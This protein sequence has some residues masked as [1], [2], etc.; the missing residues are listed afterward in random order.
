MRILTL[1]QLAIWRCLQNVRRKKMDMKK[2]RLAFRK[3][4]LQNLERVRSKTEQTLTRNPNDPS[5]WGRGFYEDNLVMK[6]TNGAI[7]GLRARHRV[8]GVVIPKEISTV[9]IECTTVH[10]S[11]FNG[12]RTHYD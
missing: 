6:K 4:R 10:Q 3:K 9:C 12:K 8:E 5:S 11:P 2:K 1:M 7:T